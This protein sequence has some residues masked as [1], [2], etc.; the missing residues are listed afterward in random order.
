MDYRQIDFPEHT[1]GLNSSFWLSKGELA[2][3]SIPKEKIHEWND[4]FNGGFRD[5]YSV[6]DSLLYIAETIYG[7]LCKLQ[8]ILTHGSLFLVISDFI[9]NTEKKFMESL[10]KTL[11]KVIMN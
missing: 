9:L 10:A 3:G 1:G 7:E 5:I 11:I 2:L 4:R 8:I 6:A